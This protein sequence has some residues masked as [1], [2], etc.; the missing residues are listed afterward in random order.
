MLPN[1]VFSS[2]S[3]KAEWEKKIIKETNEERSLRRSK[4]VLKDYCLN[5]MKEGALFVTITN[6]NQ[7]PN[8]DSELRYQ[9]NQEFKKRVLKK[10]NNLRNKYKGFEYILVPE[11]HKSG[12]IHMHGVFFG[13]PLDRLV[14][15]GKKTKHSV[16]YNLG[17]FEL[18]GFTTATFIR[19]IEKASS[20]I[21]KYISKEMMMYEGWQRYYISRG[22]QRPEIEKL[23]MSLK[24]VADQADWVR[25]V[26]KGGYIAFKNTIDSSSG[27]PDQDYFDEETE[28]IKAYIESLFGSKLRIVED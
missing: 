6:G 11:F 9:H 26:G 1:E 27:L 8:A 25:E 10:M 20:Y 24:D 22:I 3:Y 23:K 28:E 4:R 2:G 15:S 21:T 16:I 5:N 7:N 19:S 14:D 17:G 18:I 13:Y 12:Y